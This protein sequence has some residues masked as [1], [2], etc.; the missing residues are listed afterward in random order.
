MITKYDIVKKLYENV[1]IGNKMKNNNSNINRVNYYTGRS[2]FG[3]LII[4]ILF[5]LTIYD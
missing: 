3:S 5:F 4:I 1:K 2:V